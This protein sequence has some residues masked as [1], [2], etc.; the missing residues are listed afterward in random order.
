[1]Q[2]TCSC[3]AKCYCITR[4]S[5]GLLLIS[6]ETGETVFAVITYLMKTYLMTNNNKKPSTVCGKLYPLHKL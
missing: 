6:I 5:I 4:A 1:M 3:E 2:L